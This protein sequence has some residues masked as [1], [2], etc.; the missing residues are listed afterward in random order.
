MN[1][2]KKKIKIVQK[3]W[4]KEK[5]IVN[6]DYCGKLLILKKGFRCSMH[7]HK[8]KDETFFINKG[9]VFLELDG[10]KIIMNPGDSELVM[11]NQKHRFTGLEDSEIIEFSTHHEDEDSYRD[12]LSGEI[13]LSSLLSKIISSLLPT[14]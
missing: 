5:W 13:D 9:K 8:N 11:P 7:H 4:G 14:S 3:V 2:D 10:K 6:R 1:A 12:E